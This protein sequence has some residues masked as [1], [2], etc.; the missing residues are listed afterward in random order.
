MWSPVF[1][2]AAAGLFCVIAAFVGCRNVAASMMPRPVHF[3]N[4]HEFKEF[5]SVNV[6]FSHT[7]TSSGKM[8]CPSNTFHVADH[9]I[10]IDDLYDI[11]PCR[12][13]GLTLAWHGILWVSQ[14][15]GDASKVGLFPEDLGGKWRVWGNVVVAD[16]EAL[17]DCIEKMHR[18]N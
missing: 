18:T 8:V 9:A 2:K 17:M 16:D 1:S 6:L 7:G 13:C 14:L 5:A 11:S 15:Y 3:T 12:D 4:V 10:E